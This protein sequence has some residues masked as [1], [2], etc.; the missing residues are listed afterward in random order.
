MTRLQSVL[1]AQ[2]L[3]LVVLLGCVVNY[4]F[5]LERESSAD[6]KHVTSAVEHDDVETVSLARTQAYKQ[7]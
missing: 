5:A 2:A 4:N 3:L 6:N 1:G 7:H